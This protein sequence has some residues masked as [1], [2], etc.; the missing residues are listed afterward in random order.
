MYRL[1][2]PSNPAN[3]AAPASLEFSFIG[4]TVAIVGI[5]INGVEGQSL[6]F[7]VQL[8]DQK[9]STPVYKPSATASNNQDYAYQ[10]FAQTGLVSNRHTIKVGQFH[11]CSYDNPNKPLS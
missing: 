10:L 6:N 1:P 2:R 9:P 4:N 3:V 11:A 8:D 5:V 7:L